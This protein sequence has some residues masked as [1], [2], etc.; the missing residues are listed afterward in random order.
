M[1]QEKNKW[2]EDDIAYSDV[3]SWSNWEVA[4]F[5]G[6]NEDEVDYEYKLQ[7]IDKLKELNK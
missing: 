4:E 7:A 3:M 6:I 2:T 1:E 5:L